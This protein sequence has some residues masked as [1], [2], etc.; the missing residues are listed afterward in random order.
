[1][2]K[3]VFL[4]DSFLRKW[5]GLGL[6]AVTILVVG[7]CAMGAAVGV[8]IS[9]TEATA[10]LQSQAVQS[11]APTVELARM[12]PQKLI[13]RIGLEEFKRLSATYSS[14]NM[15]AD[16]LEKTGVAE[17]PAAALL[18]LRA[19][20]RAFWDGAA[21]PMLP[22][23]KRDQREFGDIKRTDGDDL[24]GIALEIQGPDAETARA[25]LDLFA[26]YLRSGVIR[27]RVRGWVLSGKADAQTMTN[28]SR[29]ELLRL[30]HEL[31]LTEKRIDAYKTVV[32][33][34]P[35]LR[36]MDARQLITVGPQNTDA[37][38]RTLSPMVQLVSAETL[39][40]QNRE[41]IGRLQRAAMQKEL[42]LKF[43]GDAQ[44]AVEKSTD[45]ATLLATL[46]KLA[47]KVFLGADKAPE[48]FKEAASQTYAKLDEFEAMQGLIGVRDDVVATSPNSRRSPARL[49]MLAVAAVIA[50][51]LVIAFVRT[52]PLQSRPRIQ[53]LDSGSDASVGR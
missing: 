9:T 25:M 34:Y 14:E 8:A 46:R 31:T 33:R 44:P 18:R 26:D 45:A 7:A 50:S 23:G 11:D 4:I 40:L 3:L 13:S 36:Q 52:G 42:L 12:G 19:K 32:A 2:R 21:Q 29:A 38:E 24:L 15:L 51:L 17:S 53:G 39:L 27:E 28:R 6:R 47:D 37:F 5:C 22:F 35:E 1:M 49:S 20:S 30:E 48:W 41:K 16:Y 43:Y 10:L